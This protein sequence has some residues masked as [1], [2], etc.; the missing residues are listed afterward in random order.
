V[1]RRPFRRSAKRIF[2]A[3]VEAPQRKLPSVEKRERSN[4]KATQ[5]ISPTA[6][7][8]GLEK[9][10]VQCGSG[11]CARRANDQDFVAAGSPFSGGPV[12]LPLAPGPHF[13]TPGYGSPHFTTL[14]PR[15]LSLRRKPFPG[16]SPHHC[17]QMEMSAFPG[18]G[19]EERGEARESL[20]GVCIQALGIKFFIH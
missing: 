5:Q 6:Q 14:S 10:P 9:D 11:S 2:G 17:I 7:Q 3:L 19:A 1:T 18:M 15:S 16:L 12:S 13:G 8:L 4:P 20:P